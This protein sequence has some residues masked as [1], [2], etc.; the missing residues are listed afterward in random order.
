MSHS[1][2]YPLAFLLYLFLHCLLVTENLVPL[3]PIIFRSFFFFIR[4]GLKFSPLAH[5]FK[6]V[7]LLL[8]LLLPHD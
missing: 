6:P 1:L 7:F 2:E 5:N 4:H 3:I 8:L